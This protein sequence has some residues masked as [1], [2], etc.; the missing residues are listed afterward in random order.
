M[1]QYEEYGASADDVPWELRDDPVEPRQTAGGVW[2]VAVEYS[3]KGQAK[4]PTIVDLLNGSYSTRDEALAA[5]QKQAF[6]YDPAVPF[7]QQDRQVF[8]D[9]PDGFLAIIQGAMS[10]FHMSVR[11]VQHLGDA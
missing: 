11:V 6:A 2:M 5:A 4:P 1:S 10:T 3:N 9:G 7:S 8:R